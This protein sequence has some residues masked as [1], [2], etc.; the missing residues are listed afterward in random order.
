MMTDKEIFYKLYAII[1]KPENY[2]PR[3]YQ[4][5]G[6]MWTVDTWRKGDVTLKIMDEGYTMIISAPQFDIHDVGAT[7]TI[8]GDREA[9]EKF[10]QENE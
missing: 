9:I 10:L 7:M 4:T 1:R 5:I 8:S 2:V 3:D 6:G